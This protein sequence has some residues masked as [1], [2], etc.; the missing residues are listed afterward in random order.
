MTV[1]LTYPYD[2]Q[3]LLDV[4]NLCKRLDIFVEKGIQSQYYHFPTQPNNNNRLKNITFL[5]HFNLQIQTAKGICSL[6]AG[7]LLHIEISESDYT[8]L[9]SILKEL[10]KFSTIT[11]HELAHLNAGAMNQIEA[12]ISAMTEL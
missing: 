10:L 8:F 2:L 6:W 11:I 9:R 7:V 12:D 1:H 3:R 5:E 4:E